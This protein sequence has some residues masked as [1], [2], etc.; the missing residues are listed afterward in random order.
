MKQLI[1]VLYVDDSPLDRELVRDALEKEHG[2]FR[3]IEAASREE[4]DARLGETDY[5][6][7]LSDFNILGFEGLQV[8][9][10]VQ[11]LQPGV[12]VVIVT[13][14]G[15]EAIAAEAIKRGAADYVIKSPQHIRRLPHT[16]HAVME[17]HR[18][19]EEHRRWQTKLQRSEERFRAVFENAPQGLVIADE[20]GSFV[21]VNRVWERMF[22]FTA[23]EAL[24]LTYRDVTYGEDI[25][26]SRTRFEGLMG[27]KAGSY[28][29]EKTVHKKG[30][31][32]FLG[33]SVRTTLQGTRER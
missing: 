12:P 21:S 10:S 30:R 4:F 11:S 18:L 13:G 26:E 20:Q 33:R 28:R 27:E 17:R 9:E 7:V 19:E 14:T 31:L 32:H 24:H 15:S 5:D 22:G 2:G 6:L 1:R 25:E 3:V 8:L 23:Q 16:I 29:L